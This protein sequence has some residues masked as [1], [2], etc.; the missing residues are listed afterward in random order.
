MKKMLKFKSSSSSSWKQE[1][2]SHRRYSKGPGTISCHSG[3]A[4]GGTAQ[5][6]IHGNGIQVQASSA[7]PLAALTAH[8]FGWSRN[9][10]YS[11]LIVLQAGSL[12]PR[13]AE[14]ASAETLCRFPMAPSGCGLA[15][16]KQPGSFPTHSFHSW[17]PWPLDLVTS[18]GLHLLLPLIP[19]LG[20]EVSAYEFRGDT[21][22]NL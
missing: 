1:S 2:M 18:E 7:S 9:H 15:Q 14:A 6:E 21:N 13:P 3:R 5:G 12:G 17:G 10:R 8:L 19:T 22:I 16:W 4:G 11:F 20:G